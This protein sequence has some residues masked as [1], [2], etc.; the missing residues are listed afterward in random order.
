MGLINTESNDKLAIRRYHNDS[1][2]NTLADLLRYYVANQP[3]KVAYTF[4]K[5]GENYQS[6][7]TFKE[8]LDRSLILATYLQ[9][10]KSSQ[11]PVLLL[12]PSGIEFII[13]FG[14]LFAGLITVPTCLPKKNRFSQRLAAICSD[15]GAELAL[16]CSSQ[17]SDLSKKTQFKSELDG[18]K[19]ID[20]EISNFSEGKYKEVNI[21]S[22]SLA[23]IQYTSGSTS[24]PRIGAKIQVIVLDTHKGQI[25]L[26]F[27]A[28]SII[29]IMRSELHRKKRLK[30]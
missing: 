5:D 10:H 22:E 17:F 26:G 16:T 25:R 8:L 4:L 29:P 28:T 2:V 14:C 30:S 7:I 12:Y 6:S 11:K 19:L 9:Q 3:D 13:S 27:E 15:S 1:S 23:F 20:T 24:E 18:L 21:T